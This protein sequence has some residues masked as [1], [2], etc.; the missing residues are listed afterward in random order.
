MGGK[1]GCATSKSYAVELLTGDVAGGGWLQIRG[2][3]SSRLSVEVGSA[4]VTENA[5]CLKVNCVFDAG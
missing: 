2:A 5:D 4:I 3:G 1:I